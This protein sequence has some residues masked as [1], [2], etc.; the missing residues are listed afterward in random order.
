MP[1]DSSHRMAA[2]PLCDLAEREEAACPLC[3]ATLEKRFRGG[4][5]RVVAFASLA[6]VALG[7]I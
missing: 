4:W 7:F 2:C 3:G 5:D 6:V 1:A